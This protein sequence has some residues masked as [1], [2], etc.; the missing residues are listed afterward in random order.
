MDLTGT[1]RLPSSLVRSTI[2]SLLQFIGKYGF[3][4]EDIETR[5]FRKTY[6]DPIVESYYDVIIDSLV[7][8]NINVIEPEL[9]LDFLCLIRVMEELLQAP[10]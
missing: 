8:D 7:S 6:F 4:R 3:R 2:K 1:T 5:L 10:R 9:I